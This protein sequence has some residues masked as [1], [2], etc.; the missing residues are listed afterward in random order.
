MNILVPMAGMGR[1]F[2]EA[3]YKNP[4]PFIDVVGVPM[5]G[6][7]IQDLL[8]LN[9]TKFTFIV[10]KDHALVV[11]LNDIFDIWC[12]V[13]YTIVEVDGVT[14]GAACTV[15]LAKK[16]IDGG[17]LIIANSDQLVDYSANIHNLLDNDST[18]G[19]IFCFKASE[20]KW[21]Y[22]RIGDMGY[23]VEVAE[24]NP[25]SEWATC[26]I[27]YYRSG[28]AFVEAAERMV[29]KNIRTNGEFYVCPVYNEL[30]EMGHKI[31]IL[32]VDGMVGLGTPED[33]NEFIQHYSTQ[34]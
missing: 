33:L 3:G 22:A 26:G 6:R 10:Q 29:S 8:K 9:P 20:S 18:D 7:V 14:E 23:V 11:N 30:I 27:Y 24:K 15:L 5:I 32:E 31:E 19:V 28:T 16:F 1:R 13:P 4:K 34:G 2:I 21:S 25:I 12:P 17:P